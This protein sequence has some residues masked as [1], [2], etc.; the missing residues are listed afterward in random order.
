RIPFVLMPLLMR[1][2]LP[3]GLRL[4]FGYD[5]RYSFGSDVILNPLSCKYLTGLCF[6]AIVATSSVVFFIVQYSGIGLFNFSVDLFR[7]FFCALRHF[8]LFF[9]HPQSLLYI[10]K[11]TIRRQLLQSFFFQLYILLN[12][13]LA[14]EM[15]FVYRIRRITKS[16]DCIE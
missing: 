6:F 7:V 1:S 13:F 15:V 12:R 11:A 9:T 14:T 5:S 10:K 16:C 8:V 2:L 3:H 4:P